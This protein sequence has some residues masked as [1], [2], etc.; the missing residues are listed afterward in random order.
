MLKTVK[1]FWAPI[2]VVKINSERSVTLHNHVLYSSAKTEYMRWKQ[3]GPSADSE[4]LDTR[5]GNDGMSILRLND[6]SLQK[7]VSDG[8]RLTINP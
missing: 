4:G 1:S 2:S 3:T 5:E 8:W 6:G 7:S